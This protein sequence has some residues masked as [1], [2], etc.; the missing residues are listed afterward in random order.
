MLSILCLSRF[1]TQCQGRQCYD[2][3]FSPTVSTRGI[4]SVSVSFYRHGASLRII[5]TSYY[6]MVTGVSVAWV[7]NR[8]D[9]CFVEVET[10]YEQTSWNPSVVFWSIFNVSTRWS[11]IATTKSRDSS[12]GY[13]DSPFD[14]VALL[15]LLRLWVRVW[16]RAQH[17]VLS[18]R[19]CRIP[20]NFVSYV[21]AFAVIGSIVSPELLK[22]LLQ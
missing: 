21:L 20:V 2:P 9:F 18:R 5:R 22:I 8:D 13:T 10:L 19:H 11:A 15:E 4:A 14:C 6:Y 3:H 17:Q 12:L 7:S 1:G 16:K